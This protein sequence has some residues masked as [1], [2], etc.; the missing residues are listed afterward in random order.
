MSVD[1]IIIGA[2]GSSRDIAQAIACSDPA[3]KNWNLLGFLDDDAAKQGTIV[4]GIPV[5]GVL[6]SVSIYS[7]AKVLIGVAGEPPTRKKLVQRLGLPDERYATFVHPSAFLSPSAEI[8]VGVA[9]LQN[10]VINTS[11]TIGSHV[12][13]SPGTAIGHDA[14]VH[15]YVVF[16]P[17][18]L[19]CGSVAIHECAFIGAR[20]VLSPGT[21]VG[22]RS[23]V[24]IGAVVVQDVEPG[25]T[26]FGNPA[27]AIITAGRQ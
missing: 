26:V 9:I 7:D 2:G 25:A 12:L 22:T 16:A 15:D 14:M 23:L 17:E 18:A 21:V 3:K 20:S 13:I 6:D 1:L 19:V 4:D 5:L 11:A 10:V 24:G 8:G 27:R